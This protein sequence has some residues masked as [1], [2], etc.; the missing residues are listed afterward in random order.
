MASIALLQLATEYLGTRDASRF[1]SKA[2][3]LLVG[4]PLLI[5]WAFA[6][7]RWAQLRWGWVGGALR[8]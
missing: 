6:L 3:A 1:L 7:F 5:V 4:L 8:S 2:I